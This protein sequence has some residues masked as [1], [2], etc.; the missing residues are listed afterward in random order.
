MLRCKNRS[1]NRLLCH[2]FVI[3]SN[4]IDI[5]IMLMFASVMFILQKS[6]ATYYVF[7]LLLL[8]RF[9]NVIIYKCFKFFPS[10]FPSRYKPIRMFIII[11]IIMVIFK[12]Y[13]SR[14]DV[15]LSY[16]K[17]CEHRIRKN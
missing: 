6:P 11:I 8:I 14:E 7:M 3:V 4:I 10:F 2:C 5:I 9:M 15:A 17:W 12:C 13:F 16:K 1:F